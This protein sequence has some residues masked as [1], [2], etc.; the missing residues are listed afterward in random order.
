MRR[1]RLRHP[2]VSSGFG[3]EPFGS[4]FPA[5]FPGL[6]RF[7]EVAGESEPVPLGLS[8]SAH[9]RGI[10]VLTAN[11]LGDE[12][13]ISNEPFTL[14]SHSPCVSPVHHQLRD[15]SLRSCDARFYLRCFSSSR[16]RIR[17]WKSLANRGRQGS[18]PVTL[19]ASSRSPLVCRAFGYGVFSGEPCT[20]A[21]CSS[22]L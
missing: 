13:H 3:R 21:R 17:G 22:S 20:V 9:C 1:L 4:L 15:C 5:L 7:G 11:R 14:S 8:P 16:R 12:E 2:V 18:H 19:S 10:K 6:A